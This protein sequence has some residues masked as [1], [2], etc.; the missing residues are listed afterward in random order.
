MVV[1]RRHYHLAPG[2]QAV[3]G[4]MNGGGGV[5]VATVD[6][7]HSHERNEP[8]A[9]RVPER[10]T[11]LGLFKTDEVPRSKAPAMRGKNVCRLHGGKAGAPIG[12]RNGR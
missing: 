2:S 8:D 9:M 12:E 6:G 4:D 7:G 3:F 1:D 5:G 10:P 11:M